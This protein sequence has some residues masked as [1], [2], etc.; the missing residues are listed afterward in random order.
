M[1]FNQIAQR[2]EQAFESDAIVTPEFKSFATKFRNALK[3]ELSAAGAE[4]VSFSR[5]HFDISGLY[6]IKG[7]LGYFSL[8]DVRSAGGFGMSNTPKLMYRT[9]E[10]EKDY[11]GGSNQWV[12]IE[13]GAGSAMTKNMTS[14]SQRTA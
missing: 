9:A 3:K 10:H 7:Q 4:L 14:I 12:N 2:L 8:P 11:S 13:N 1:N 6:R 5:G